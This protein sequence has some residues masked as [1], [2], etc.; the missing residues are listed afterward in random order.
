MNYQELV[1]RA[2]SVRFANMEMGLSKAREQ[3]SFIEAVSRKLDATSWEYHVRMSYEFDVTFNIELGLVGLKHQY[4]AIKQALIEQFDV[5][6][7][8]DTHPVLTVTCTRTGCSCRVIFGDV[9]Q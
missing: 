2:L 8:V 5:E 7:G 9:P 1:A 6:F 4:Q 3:Q